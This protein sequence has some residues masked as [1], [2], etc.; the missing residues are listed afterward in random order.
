MA[1]FDPAKNKWSTVG[2]TT[3]RRSFPRCTVLNGEIYVVGGLSLDHEIL[4]AVEV[5][6]PQENR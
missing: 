4:D 2:G 6:N 3:S 5:Y 1:G